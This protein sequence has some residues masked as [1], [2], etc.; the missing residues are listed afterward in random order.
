MEQSACLYTGLTVE[1]S[2]G[3][4][5]AKSMVLRPLGKT[6]GVSVVYSTPSTTCLGGKI[7]MLTEIEVNCDKLALQPRL[8][9]TEVDQVLCN[10]RI[11]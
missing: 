7:E 11:E 1:S 3:L 6:D 10:T 4:G 9:R 5:D 8:G 2:Y